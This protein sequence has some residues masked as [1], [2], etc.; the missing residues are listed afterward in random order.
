MTVH[1]I[2]CFT[3]KQYKNCFFLEVFSKI[4]LANK[5]STNSTVKLL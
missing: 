5:L 3:D 1:A 4:F 2:S